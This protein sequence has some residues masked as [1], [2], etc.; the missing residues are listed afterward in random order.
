MFDLKRC[1]IKMASNIKVVESRRGKVILKNDL[2]LKGL[3]RNKEYEKLVGRLIKMMR[4]I[5]KVEFLYDDLKIVISY[6]WTRTS[7]KKVVNWIK[8]IIEILIDNYEEIKN[9]IE[10]NNKEELIKFIE[11]QVKNEIKFIKYK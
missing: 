11:H 8:L 10:R 6:D 3:L 9:F 4:E 5:N 7:E 2:I 1:A